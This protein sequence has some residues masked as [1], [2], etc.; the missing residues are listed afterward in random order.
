LLRMPYYTGTGLDWY[1]LLEIRLSGI[2]NPYSA[3]AP[4]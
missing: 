4:R 2:I 1:E 3:V